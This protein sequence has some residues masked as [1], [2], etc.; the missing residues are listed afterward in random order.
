[1]LILILLLIVIV[2]HFGRVSVANITNFSQDLTRHSVNDINNTFRK[3]KQEVWD[4]K[5]LF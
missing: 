4:D 1:M 5:F 3:L 2:D